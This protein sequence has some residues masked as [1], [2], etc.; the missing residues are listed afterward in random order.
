MDITAI[1]QFM[2]MPFDTF[3][4]LL[5][6]ASIVI[7]LVIIVY[8]LKYVIDLAPFAYTNARIRS[9]EA[10][11]LSEDKLNELIEAGGIN[12]LIGF[13]DDTEYGPYI[14]EVMNE[15]ND[16]IAIEKALN[17]HLADVYQTLS[18]ISPDEAKKTLNLLA[19]K[20]DIKNIKTLLRA[21]FVGLN[22]EETFKLLIP[23]GTIPVNKLRE[24][25]ET[26]S[27]DEVVSGLEGTEYAPVLS[28]ALAKF[29]QTGNLLPLELAL[30]K[31]LLEKLWK[32]VG[33]EGKEKDLF[34]EFVGRMV[35]IESIKVILRG[36]ADKLPSD[37]LSEYLVNIG[38]ELAPWKLKELADADSI[39]GVVSSLEGTVYAQILADAMEEYEKT[40]SVY[41]FEK[42]LDK[43]LVELGKKLSLRKPFGV[44]PIIGFITAKELEIRNLKIIIKGKLENLPPN[45]IRTLIA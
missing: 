22:E 18:N 32:T 1:A 29:E 36:K 6:L 7:F 41:A 5:I 42:A 15:L 40:K 38:Y 30:D 39:E 28:E 10:R 2:N 27:V 35:D 24:L 4:I 21:K 19:K 16:P 45:Q 12:E 17:M 3:M 9:M 26:K 13:L 31:Y 11:L 44:G 33:I 37:V 34:K 25:S 14:S 20:F 23:L 43:Y 8:I